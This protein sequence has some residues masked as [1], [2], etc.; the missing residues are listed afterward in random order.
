MDQDALN[1]A[2]KIIRL[3][4]GTDDPDEGLR[5]RFAEWLTDGRNQQEKD[6]A[7]FMLF[8]DMDEAGAPPFE[9]IAARLPE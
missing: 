3:Y 6:A 4:F 5:R 9:T 8:E 7:M 1:R 2:V